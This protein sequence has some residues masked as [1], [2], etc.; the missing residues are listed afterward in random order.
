[1]STEFM[2]KMLI[3]ICN[4]WKSEDVLVHY[5]CSCRQLHEALL[6]TSRSLDPRISS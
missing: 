1:M 3:E 5:D 2:W 6:M 4:M